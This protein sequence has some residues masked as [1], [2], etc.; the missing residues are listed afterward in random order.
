MR[1]GEAEFLRLLVHALDEGVHR[2]GGEGG[3]G[4]GGIVA[5]A[6]HQAV[7]QVLIAQALARVDG[8][9]R[10]IAGHLTCGSGRGDDLLEIP[11]LDAEQQSHDL[12][13]AGGVHALG[14]VLVQQHLAAVR[15]DEYG[16]LRVEIAGAQG[17]GVPSLYM[18]GVQMSKPS[19][20]E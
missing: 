4:V 20:S 3:N 12:G 16:C 14:G 10:G 11:P 8:H 13:G 19:S 17:E 7:E 15:V 9:A 18:V 2:A 6:D 1:A 5:G